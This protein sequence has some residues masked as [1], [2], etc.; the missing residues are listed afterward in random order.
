M[1]ITLRTLKRDH[2]LCIL[3]RRSSER[4]AR[5]EIARERLAAF[6]CEAL[7]KTVE[8][9]DSGRAEKVGRFADA[10]L[11]N[12]LRKHPADRLRAMLDYWLP[13][14]KEE[15]DTPEEYKMLPW[16]VQAHECLSSG[17]LEGA[18][19]A[20]RDLGS[21]RG[22]LVPESLDMTSDTWA[23]VIFTG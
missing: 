2:L 17:D 12:D 9:H 18:F 20:M 11:V 14:E 4:K 3:A 19:Y 10:R 6:D 23:D 13:L 1:P 5:A 15:N 22:A 7:R 8:Y 21:K 16:L